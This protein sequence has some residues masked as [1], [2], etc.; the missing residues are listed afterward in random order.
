MH[1]AL[2]VTLTCLLAPLSVASLPGCTDNQNDC[3]KTGEC[4]G[5]GAPT[6]GSGGSVSQGPGGGGAGGIDPGCMPTE[7]G[8]GEAPADTCGIFV[9]ASGDN[10]GDGSKDAPKQTVAAALEAAS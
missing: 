5:G 9:S 2:R 10:G 1:A 6:G 7:L 8:E 4:A 3:T